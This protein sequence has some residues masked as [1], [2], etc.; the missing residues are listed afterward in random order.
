MKKEPGA[1]CSSGHS[2]RAR[3]RGARRARARSAD[4][5][6][7]VPG[8]PWWIAASGNQGL[9]LAC[10]GSKQSFWSAR[11]RPARARA[12]ARALV[13]TDPLVPRSLLALR[14]FWQSCPAGLN[15]SSIPQHAT[16]FPSPARVRPQVQ[17]GRGSRDSRKPH[18][19][20]KGV[21]SQHASFA[22]HL[23]E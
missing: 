18:F 17:E 3:A 15:E 6:L 1:L 12:R 14:S 20:F 8:R 13:P 11:A 23:L 22:Y 9:V 16:T 7:L 4:G 2:L 21:D 5:Q 19:F 10:S